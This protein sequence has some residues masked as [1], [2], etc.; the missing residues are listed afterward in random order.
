MN[1]AFLFSIVHSNFF[2]MTKSFTSK[3]VSSFWAGV[4]LVVGLLFAAGNVQAQSDHT[5]SPV[6]SWVSPSEALTRVNQE[7]AALDQ[8]LSNGQGTVETKFRL[9]YYEQVGGNLEGGMG[10]S[11]SLSSA[12]D[13]V[14]GDT[15]ADSMPA[16]PISNAQLLAIVNDAVNLLSF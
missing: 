8:L 11:E 10:I 9:Y 7:K 13:V 15:Q 1:S 16:Q 14:H 6:G 4:C 2:K 3:K 5:F 12:Y